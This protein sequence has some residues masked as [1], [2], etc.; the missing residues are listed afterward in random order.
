MADECRDIPPSSTD[1]EVNLVKSYCDIYD[2][3][4]VEAQNLR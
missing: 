4:A 2:Q 3:L 1:R